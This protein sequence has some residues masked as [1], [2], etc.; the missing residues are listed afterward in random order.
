MLLKNLDNEVAKS[1]K[2]FHWGI[3]KEGC[4]S[5]KSKLLIAVASAVAIRCEPCLNHHVQEALQEGLTP[6]EL[7]ES[8]AVATLICTGSRLNQAALI[9]K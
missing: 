1:F 5:R 6:E 7:L 2:Q 4:L 9:L 3:M 8:A